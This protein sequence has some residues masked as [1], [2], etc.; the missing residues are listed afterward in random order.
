MILSL[1]SEEWGSYALLLS[2]QLNGLQPILQH[3]KQTLFSLATLSV[4]KKGCPSFIAWDPEKIIAVF[5]LV[6]LNSNFSHAIEVS[7]S[8]FCQIYTCLSDIFFKFSAGHR[9]CDRVISEHNTMNVVECSLHCLRKPSVCKSINYKARK[10]QQPSRNC[11]LN[12]A[13]KTT[14][15][16]NLL[17]DKNYDYYSEPLEKV[18]L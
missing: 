11:Q 16:Q 2:A 12:N 15:P 17:P 14:H 5:T 9:L 4:L 10:H 1:C 6:K 3:Y 18:F 8:A 7:L 13:T